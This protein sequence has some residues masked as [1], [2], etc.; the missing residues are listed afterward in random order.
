MFSI[1]EFSSASGIPVRTLRFYHE[2]GL[3]VPAAIDD[4]T[5]YRTYDLRNLEIARV[6]VALRELEFSEAI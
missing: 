3:L 1:G 6:I 5:N 2:Q 4:A